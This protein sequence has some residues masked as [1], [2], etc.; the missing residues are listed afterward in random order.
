ML[1][2]TI[3]LGG[4]YS[5]NQHKNEYLTSFT[6]TFFRACGNCDGSVEGPKR[7]ATHATFETYQ[8]DHDGRELTSRQISFRDNGPSYCQFTFCPRED[9]KPGYSIGGYYSVNSYTLNN[10]TIYKS[11]GERT[12]YSESYSV[13]D[14][15]SVSLFTSDQ[16]DRVWTSEIFLP[17]IVKTKI[18]V[19]SFVTSLTSVPI[20]SSFVKDGESLK[21]VSYNVKS[22]KNIQTQ[23]VNI[24]GEAISKEKVRTTVG[25]S[26]A[27]TGS[28]FPESPSL[29]LNFVD[30]VIKI[31]NN[32][33]LW[34]QTRIN[35]KGTSAS[36][37]QNFKSTHGIGKQFTVKYEKPNG[38]EIEIGISKCPYEKGGPIQIDSKIETIQN[39][40]T[41]LQFDYLEKNIKINVG[42][43]FPISTEFKLSPVLTTINSNTVVTNFSY[44]FINVTLKKTN[45]PVFENALEKIE[46]EGLEF[47][48]QFFKVTNTGFVKTFYDYSYGRCITSNATF[49]EKKAF[50]T[51]DME[52]WSISRYGPRFQELHFNK[53]FSNG[54]ASPNNLS[55][56]E[57]VVFT[58]GVTY[59]SILDGYGGRLRRWFRANIYPQVPVPI[60]KIQNTFTFLDK[61]STKTALVLT[62][63]LKKVLV[64]SS[65]SSFSKSV[66]VTEIKTTAHEFSLKG[67]APSTFL[68]LTKFP[69]AIKEFDEFG[70]NENFLLDPNLIKNQPA[71]LDGDFVGQQAFVDQQAALGN[72][73]VF[74]DD[75]TNTITRVLFPGDVLAINIDGIQNSVIPKVVKTFQNKS[76]Y[77][78]LRWNEKIVK[79]TSNQSF[80]LGQP[81]IN[82]GFQSLTFNSYNFSNF[83]PN[84]RSMTGGR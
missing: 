58:D 66:K 67:K 16:W 19:K 52:I 77:A 33:I 18:P 54:Q 53:D 65:S 82:P 78:Y 72:C 13:R 15:K 31:T 40:K 37:S 36:L 11:N 22:T 76:S 17:K 84:V 1:T 27:G 49:F 73:G 62:S 61:N 79:N 26:Y 35:A 7:T 59:S 28:P 64:S 24:E 83:F 80:K 71:P 3:S 30:T 70:K 47:E 68:Y 57:Q 9:D 75:G 14:G 25:R 41:F 56:G 46:V 51:L 81:V 55:I 34:Y 74:C 63:N 69:D 39:A 50:S 44:K 45:V 43:N 42:N 29:N 5:T 20:F 21:L 48:R 32:N 6:S 60:L 8:T 23:I 4:I 10:Y 38:R 12:E 2:Y